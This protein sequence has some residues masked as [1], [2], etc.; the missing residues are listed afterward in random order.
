MNSPV[1][2]NCFVLYARDRRNCIV[3]D[4]G[5]CN[6]ADLLVFLRDHH[7]NVEYILLTHEHFDHIWGINTLKEAFNCKIACSRGCARHI[8]DKR[9]NLSMFYDKVGFQT[10]SADIIVE[11]NG[12]KVLWNDFVIEFI[13]SPGHSDGSVCIKIKDKLFTGDT[14]IKNRKTITK[15]PEGDKTKLSLSLDNI[16]NII[17]GHRVIVYPGHGEHF[18][19]EELSISEYI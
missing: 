7:L 15:L 19:L 12:S 4:P 3:I 1:D 9:K 5:T 2:S 16:A 10:I 6:C 18:F 8:V 14:I 17:N 11:D 13:Y